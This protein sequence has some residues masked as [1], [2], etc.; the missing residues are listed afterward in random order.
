MRIKRYCYIVI[1]IFMGLVSVSCEDWFDVKPDNQITS[2]ELY[3]TGSGYRMQL[4]GIYQSLASTSLYGKELSWGFLDVLGQYYVREKLQQDYRDVNDRNYGVASVESYIDG[5]WSNMYHVIADCNDLMEHIVHAD[6]SMFEYGRIEY[7]KI[8][9]EALAIRAMCHFDLLRLFAPSPKADDGGTYIPYV[10]NSM[11][12]INT[13]LTVDEVLERVIADM[14]HASELLVE[15]DSSMVYAESL[16]KD[17]YRI[18]LVFDGGNFNISVGTESTAMFAWT[19][20]YRMHYC[21][22]KALLARIYFYM[23]RTQEAYELAKFVCDM[24]DGYSKAFEF[25][26]WLDGPKFHGDVIFALY[27]ENNE[28]NYAP[29]ANVSN[30]LVLRNLLTLFPGDA[31]MDARFTDQTRELGDG[32]GFISAKNIATDWGG[33]NSLIAMIP[34]IRLSE[35]YYIMCEYL[36][37][38]N[39]VPSEATTLLRDL[40]RARMDYTS[41]TSITNSSQFLNMVREDARREFIGEGQSFFYYKALNIPVFDGANDVNLGSEYYL[42]IPDS[43]HVVL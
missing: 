27:N 16:S 20:R 5:I 18:E 6:T 29:Y 15:W 13:P 14:E 30:P 23:G 39:T 12:T 26:S 10:E 7:A 35:L 38:G 43:E 22:V 24:T 34:M 28:E 37:E 41:I 42:P 19:P 40:K 1:V 21:A 2:N 3:S 33:D 36:C 4:N 25:D 17:A 32:S 31:G 11:G 8:Y 9:G